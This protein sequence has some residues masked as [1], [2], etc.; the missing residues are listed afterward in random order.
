[1]SFQCRYDVVSMLKRRRVSTWSVSRS[2]GKE[3]FMF[4]K[5]MAQRIASKTGERYEKIMSIIRCTLWFLI[6]RC[7][8]MCIRGS[9]SLQK[10]G[11]VYDFVI[12]DA[13]SD[14]VAFLQFGKREKHPWRIVNFSTKVNTPPWVFFTFSKLYK[15]YC[16]A[17]RTTFVCDRS[18]CLWVKQFQSS[19]IYFL[20]SW[21]LPTQS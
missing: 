1:M 9:G 15:C 10:S 7:C 3:C 17:Q 14:L 4:H 6:L 5:H 2:F 13:L 11:I 12:C 21:H 20:T 18:K 8:S 19:R 16:I